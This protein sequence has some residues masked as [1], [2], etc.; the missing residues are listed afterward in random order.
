MACKCA[1]RCALRAAGCARW[2]GGGCSR[3]QAAG[4]WQLLRYRLVVRASG[5]TPVTMAEGRGRA[6]SGLAGRWLK[7]K[8]AHLPSNLRCPPSKHTLPPFPL[9][10]DPILLLA[11]IWRLLPR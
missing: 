2:V 8:I 5:V 10:S 6:D 7:S 4:S 9:P 11:Q 3:Q 1:L